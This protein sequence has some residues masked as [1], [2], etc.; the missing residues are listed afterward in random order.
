MGF[1]RLV[2]K[3]IKD[4]MIWLLIL[5]I[6]LQ[7]DMYYKF[8]KVTWLHLLSFNIVFIECIYLAYREGAKFSSNS[9]NNY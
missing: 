1:L 2:D 9:I 3:N 5:L 6:L 4:V 8:D 7:I